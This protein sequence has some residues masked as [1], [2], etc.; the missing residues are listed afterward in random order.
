M[1]TTNVFIFQII[2]DCLTCLDCKQEYLSMKRGPLV[3]VLLYNPFGGE[4]K[5]QK[6]CNQSHS[7]N[8][9]FVVGGGGGAS[10]SDILGLYIPAS[11]C[12]IGKL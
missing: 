12:P 6:I 9:F 1:A 8:F 5:L 4:F 10:L 7:S 3:E 11:A 2:E